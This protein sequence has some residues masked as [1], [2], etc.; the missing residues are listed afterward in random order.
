MMYYIERGMGGT[1]KEK[2]R[3]GEEEEENGREVEKIK[4]KGKREGRKGEA[5]KEGEG[6]MGGGC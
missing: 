5:S 4:G 2:G 6:E 1:G 3:R